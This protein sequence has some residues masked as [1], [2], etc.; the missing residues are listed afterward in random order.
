M[1]GDLNLP[2]LIVYLSPDQQYV[3]A[4][5]YDLKEDPRRSQKDEAAKVEKMLLADKSPSMGDTNAYVKV[6]VFSD[7]QCVFCKR[8]AEIIPGV[9]EIEG[10]NAVFIFKQYPLPMHDWANAA[11]EA[12]ACLAEQNEKAFWTVHDYLL[13][14]QSQIK[15]SNIRQQIEEIIATKVPAKL[16]SFLSCMRSGYGKGIVARDLELG[17]RLGVT[18]TPTLFI[19]GNKVSGIGGAA[20][21]RTLMRTATVDK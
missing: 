17:H 14:N 11:A 5:L 18:G 1:S 6:V 12:T 4:F 8:L 3:T 16:Q 7:Y 2:Q 13:A 19:N 15:G 20:E 10:K 9:R 21:L